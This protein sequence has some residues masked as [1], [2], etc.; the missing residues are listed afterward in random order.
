ME[1]STGRQRVPEEVFTKRL[2]VSVPDP[3]EQTTIAH[4]LDAVDA[5]LV[6]TRTRI[7]RARDVKSSVLQRFFYDALGET[8]YANRPTRQL[9]RGWRV[10]AMESLLAEEPKNGV[11]PNASSQPPGTP[12]FSI[13]AI[14]DG[15]VYLDTPDHV[16]YT[17][18]P[19]AA[20]QRFRV[21][22]GAVLIVHGN[23]NPNLVGKAGIVSHFPN[24]CPRFS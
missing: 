19:L 9:P 18:L 12:T 22:R 16:K 6:S 4:I 5:A 14:R 15:R 8:A 23:A 10:T 21:Q 3:K 24:D 1:G 11:S 13:A 7:E 20:S 2:L 17:R